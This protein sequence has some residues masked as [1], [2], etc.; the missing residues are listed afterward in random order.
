MIPKRER[1]TNNDQTYFVTSNSVGRKPF[2]RHERW[3]NLLL[4]TL[5]NYRPERYLLHA[6][7]LMPDHFHL[8][9]TP[10]ASLELA[11]QCLKGGFSFRARRELGWKG[12]IW[13]AGFADH[14]IRDDDDYEIH[15]AYIAHNPVKAGLAEK[16]ADYPYCSENGSFHTDSFPRGLKP[17]SV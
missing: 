7:V 14:R 12:E 9:I 5:F 4:E 6:F 2:F 13:V 16:P 11:V 3:A 17:Q 15:L 1:A 10:Q 8:I